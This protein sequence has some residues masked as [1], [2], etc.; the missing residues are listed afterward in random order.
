MARVQVIFDS[1]SGTRAHRGAELIPSEIFL[2][3]GC[4]DGFPDILFIWSH[5]LDYNAVRNN[6]SQIKYRGAFFCVNPAGITVFMWIRLSHDDLYYFN[7]L[8]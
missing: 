2:L 7:L 1:A 3:T 6:L 8:E 5:S 4:F